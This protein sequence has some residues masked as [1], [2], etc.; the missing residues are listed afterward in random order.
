MFSLESPDRCESNEYRQSTISIYQKQIITLIISNL[1]GMEF[2]LRTQE[3]IRNSQ[4]IRATSVAVLLYLFF[5]RVFC[6][7]FQGLQREIRAC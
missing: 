4:G 1:H 5:H 2:F 6:A 3:H 7:S